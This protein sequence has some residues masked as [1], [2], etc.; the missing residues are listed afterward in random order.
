MSASQLSSVLSCSRH[1]LQLVLNASFWLSLVTSIFRS[2]PSLK[3]RLSCS[4][5]TSVLAR[6]WLVMYS[7][8]AVITS[9]LGGWWVSEAHVDESA[10]LPSPD[11]QLAGV[12][13]AASIFDQ[14]E[15]LGY[16][17]L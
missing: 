8:A 9:R 5:C 3:P 2:P 6:P 16:V 17:G 7:Y 4:S 13:F 10:G 14:R 1:R 11:R 12:A 15:G